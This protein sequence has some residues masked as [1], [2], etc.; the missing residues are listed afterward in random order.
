MVEQDDEHVMAFFLCFGHSF[1]RS[2]SFEILKSGSF[3]LSFSPS[4]SAL[5]WF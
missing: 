1:P 4:F 5:L 3:L 2:S